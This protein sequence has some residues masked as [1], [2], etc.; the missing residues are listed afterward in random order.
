MR[1][2]LEALQAALARRSEPIVP[3]VQHAF[4]VLLDR[5]G[6]ARPAVILASANLTTWARVGLEAVELDPADLRARRPRR[7]IP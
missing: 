3:P 5:L 4:V 6:R 2:V 7:G 1:R